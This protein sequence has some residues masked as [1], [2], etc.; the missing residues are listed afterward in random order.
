MKGPTFL[1]QPTASLDY[2][3]Y[4]AAMLLAAPVVLH[5]HR[6][7]TVWRVGGSHCGGKH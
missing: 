6:R 4:P 3:A 1:M 7:R 5:H 2:A